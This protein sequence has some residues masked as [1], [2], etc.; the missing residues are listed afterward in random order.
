MAPMVEM[1]LRERFI[2]VKHLVFITNDTSKN[3]PKQE[4]LMSLA[5][6]RGIRFSWYLNRDGKLVNFVSPSGVNHKAVIPDF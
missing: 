3:Y 1:F 5:R 2:K 4:A 6:E